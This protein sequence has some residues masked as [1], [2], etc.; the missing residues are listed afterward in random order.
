MILLDTHTVIWLMIAPE[1]LSKRAG[2]AILQA[3]RDGEEIA[4]SQI[5]FYEI[6]YS[7]FRKRLL[8]SCPVKD[9]IA[10]IQ[11]KLKVIPLT[12]PIALCAAEFPAPFHGDPMDR[13]IAATAI[14]EGCILITKDE[15]IQQANLCKLLW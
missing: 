10:A 3:S 4:C 6:A 9:F 8:L 2:A 15:K 11:T 5:S 13:I 14:V 7:A 1:R 12:T